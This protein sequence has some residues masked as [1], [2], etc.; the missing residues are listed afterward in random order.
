M[1][2]LRTDSLQL[3]YLHRYITNLCR[4]SRLG[5]PGL[6]SVHT[7]LRDGRDVAYLNNKLRGIK[8]W[9]MTSRLPLPYNSI[10]AN[11]VT[12][13]VGAVIGCTLHTALCRSH[14]ALVHVPPQRGA[15][16]GYLP[17]QAVS[18]SLHA[19]EL[20]MRLSEAEI[21]TLSPL[22]CSYLARI[23]FTQRHALVVLRLKGH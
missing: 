21:I 6:A 2:L 20:R 14:C 7:C 5:C 15:A 10:V 19:Y 4:D 11:L 18:F 17:S 3:C 9:R 22:S 16:A 13:R 8:L 23:Q 12:V 1:S